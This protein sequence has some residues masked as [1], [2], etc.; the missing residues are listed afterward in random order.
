ML[1]IMAGKKKT[2][3]VLNIK[4]AIKGKPLNQLDE[5]TILTN[6]RIAIVDKAPIRNITASTEG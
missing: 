5:A 4:L 2:L 1:R 3:A 6:G